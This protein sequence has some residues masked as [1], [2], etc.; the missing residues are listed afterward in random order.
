[1]DSEHEDQRRG[2][3]RERQDRRKQRRQV[4]AR[5]IGHK[6]RQLDAIGKFKMPQVNIR[7]VRPVAMGIAAILFMVAII[8]AVRLFKDQPDEIDPN[9]IW[10]GRA[11]TYTVHDDDTIRDLAERLREQ[12][13]GSVYAYVSELNVDNTWTGLPD[14]Q[15]R[16]SEVQTTVTAFVEQFKRAAPEVNLYGVVVFRVDLDEDGYR[17]DKPSV[18]RAITEFSAR[19]VQDLGFDGVFL[20]ADPFVADG[21]TFFRDL[22]RQVRQS[23]GESALLAVAVPPDWTPVGV[24]IPMTTLIAPGTA[25]DIQYKKQ[26]ALLQADQIVLR[27]YDSYMTADDNFTA[28]DYVDW[29]SYQVQSFAEAIASLKIQTKLIVAISTSESLLPAH[30]VR[31][32]NVTSSLMGVRRGLEALPPEVVPVVQGVAIYAD[33]TT[34]DLE[35]TQFEDNWLERR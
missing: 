4:M 33:E 9:A 34:S 24:N 22:L 30:D 18:Q 27:V 20:Q 28:N 32:E 16:F 14:Q 29:V 21:D 35:W 11:W 1:M 23:I 6:P 15:N 3:A 2:K 31:V 25:W 5:P 7:Y 26:I 17:L 12:Q 19:V 13:I 8:F 10:L